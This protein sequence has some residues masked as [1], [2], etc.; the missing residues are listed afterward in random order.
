MER[1]EKWLRVGQLVGASDG[2]VEEARKIPLMARCTSCVLICGEPGTGKE[3]CARTIH[4]LSD[5]RTGPFVSM[6]CKAVSTPEGAEVDLFGRTSNDSPPESG[7]IHAAEGGTLFLDGV[8]HLPH[9]VQVKLLRFIREEGR[10]YD[11]LLAGEAVSV[12]VIASTDGDPGDSVRAGRLTPE[13]HAELNVL[14]LKMFPLRQRREDIPLLVNHFVERFRRANGRPLLLLSGDAVRKLQLHDWPGNVAELEHFLE[15]AVALC[16]RDQ[17]TGQDI[18]LDC[19][20]PLEEVE[21]F[22]E[23]KARF[24]EG[25]E[26]GYIEKLLLLH[27]GNISRAARSAQKDRRAFW[28][29]IRKHGIDAERYRDSRLPAADAG[30]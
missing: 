25:F 29:L 10:R 11:G 18:S 7:R 14:P 5:R 27:R 13:L 28:E 6:D 23:A 4:H 9:L 2:F 17:I 22:R 8:D 1:V 30:N 19:E 16:D 15:R 12:R 20:Q 24:V 26:K 21:P 3:A